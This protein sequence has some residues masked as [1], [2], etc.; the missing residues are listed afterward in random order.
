[1]RLLSRE[2][3]MAVAALMWESRLGLDVGGV[4]EP[5]RGSVGGIPDCIGDIQADLREILDRSEGSNEEGLAP[6]F[7]MSSCCLRGR[8]EHWALGP[9][10]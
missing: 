8:V 10:H 5:S 4:A 1:V 7:T 2:K 6:P 3:S 9:A